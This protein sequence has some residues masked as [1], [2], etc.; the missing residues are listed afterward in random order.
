MKTQGFALQIPPAYSEY[1]YPLRNALSA[2]SEKNL[3]EFGRQK[4]KMGFCFYRLTSKELILK[5]TEA[6]ISILKLF[7]G[8][9]LKKLLKKLMLNIHS[10]RNAYK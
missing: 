7:R 4:D 10:F 8:C 1:H 2:V 3:K 5:K 6:Q 9:F